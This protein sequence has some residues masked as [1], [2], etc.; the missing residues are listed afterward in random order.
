MLPRAVVLPGSDAGS[1]VVK[2]FKTVRSRAP[3]GARCMGHDI[4][5]WSAACSEAHLQFRV[6]VRPHLWMEEWN[7]PT[8]VAGG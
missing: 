4:R 1:D 7:L 3:C 8:P 6:G 5:T 2:S